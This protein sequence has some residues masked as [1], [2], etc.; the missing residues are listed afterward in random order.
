MLILQL[1]QG[2]CWLVGD[3]C[4]R[5]W[6]E[7][8]RKEDEIE[9]FNELLTLNNGI[10]DICVLRSDRIL[11]GDMRGRVSQ[12]DLNHVATEIPAIRGL[13]HDAPIKCIRWQPN[14]DFVFA[15]ASQNGDCHF[16]DLRCS[17]P[18]IGTLRFAHGKLALSF[19]H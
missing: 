4:G 15:T 9:G 1:V 8:G 10:A 5:V 7:E 12:F 16:A 3:E 13:D 14:S 6:I 18:L 2:N 11:M 19:I 17:S